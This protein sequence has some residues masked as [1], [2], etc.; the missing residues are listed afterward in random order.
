M[1]RFFL[2]ILLMGS[3][4]LSAEA[5]EI[6]DLDIISYEKLIQ[7]DSQTLQILEKA[8]HEKGIV[9]VRGVPGHRDKYEQ[10]IKAAREFSELPEEIKE[11]SKPNRELG[12]TFL[13][14][15]VGKEKFQRPNGEWVI[16]DLKTSYYA[17]VP[18][19]PSNKWPSE[20][21]LK[22]PF[23]ALG[24][25]MGEMGELIMYKIGLLGDRTGFYLEDD[26]CLGRMLYYR[27]SDHDGNP[28]WCGAH[29]DHSLF[30]AILPATYFVNGE[31]ISEPME[32]GLFVRTSAEAPYKKVI[33]NDLDVMMFQVGEFGQLVTNDGIRATEHRVHKAIGAI[34]RYT[35][36][37]FFKAPQDI[38]IYS[39][40]VLTN[41][42]RYGAKA[43]EAYTYRQW[44]DATFHRYLVPS[45][46][47]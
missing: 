45:E 15:E 43:G 46:E 6:L 29:F 35:L 11:R 34:E 47:K 37:V 25:L 2:S 27:K 44:D 1:F 41:D 14:Y 38:P 23:Q 39:T 5:V 33:A 40:S 42:P 10:F 8:L 32:A 22:G 18:D 4:C 28:H 30:T 19:N 36:A 16:D 12:E 13:G 24:E 26:A 3:V 20:V 7:E 9:G 17:C 31:Q 21:D